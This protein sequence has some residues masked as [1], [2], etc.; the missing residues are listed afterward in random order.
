VPQLAV[1][2]AVPHRLMDLGLQR[3]RVQGLRD[4]IERRGRRRI[5]GGADHAPRRRH[6][7]V[8]RGAHSSARGSQRVSVAVAGD[9]LALGISELLA[10]REQFVDR[11][12]L[13]SRK[14]VD[15]PHCHRR[16]TEL[17]DALGVVAMPVGAQRSRQC[18][19]LS[20]EPVTRN[21]V[22]RALV[23][24]GHGQIVGPRARAT[25]MGRT[26]RLRRRTS[27]GCPSGA[28]ACAGWSLFTIP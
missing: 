9:Q 24:N 28:A 18:V 12:R 22:Q 13:A 23:D 6:E 3:G 11:V 25:D 15:R 16:L 8:D 1:Q 5:A 10:C 4:A 21:A 7:C 26:P 17:A 19:A 27:S 14:L 20:H 2:A